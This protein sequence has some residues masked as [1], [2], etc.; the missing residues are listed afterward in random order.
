MMRAQVIGS[1]RIGTASEVLQT[2]GAIAATVGGFLRTLLRGA[3]SYNPANGGEVM[4]QL[5]GNG[6][7]GQPWVDSFCDWL[8]RF[9]PDVWQSGDIWDYPGTFA[10]RSF[11]KDHYT[12]LMNAGLPA[13]IRLDQNGN[14]EGLTQAAA[15]V[16]AA[17]G[18]GW[19]VEQLMDDFGLSLDDIIAGNGIPPR[20]GSTPPGGGGA[21]AGDRPTTTRP[22]T[23]DRNVPPE[24][25]RTDSGSML[26]L[27]A[28]GAVGLLLMRN[29]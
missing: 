27:L 29:R 24:P 2:V 21:P 23:G 5:Q 22:P 12:A 20:P 16:V 6:D 28:L 7:M 25:P 19:S 1:T 10:H 14:P 8:Q 17:D 4:R 9:R 26:P 15:A 11:F 13:G 3:G 18:T